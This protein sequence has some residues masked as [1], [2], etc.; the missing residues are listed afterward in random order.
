MRAIAA[1]QLERLGQ[2]SSTFGAVLRV[3]VRMESAGLNQCAKPRHIQFVIAERIEAQGEP[4]TDQVWLL[5]GSVGSQR[6]L[7]MRPG[8]AEIVL[9]SRGRQL[10][11]QQAK[12]ELTAVRVIRLDQE[13]GQQSDRLAV[14][15][16]DRSQLAIR[17]LQAPEKGQN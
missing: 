7:K 6:L 13:V 17:D 14:G 4:I 5:I 8:H 11:P 9:S 3:R 2:A 12:Q 16:G 1:H 15:K 10:R